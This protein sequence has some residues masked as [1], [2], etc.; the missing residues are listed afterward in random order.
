MVLH[1]YLQTIN[2]SNLHTFFNEITISLTKGNVNPISGRGSLWPAAY[3]D[4]K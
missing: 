3:F 1:E 4:P 2:Y